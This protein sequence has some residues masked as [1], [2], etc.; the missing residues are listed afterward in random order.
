MDDRLAEIRA[1]LAD[2]RNVG[3]IGRGDV[4]R[5]LAEVDRLGAERDRY[6]ANRD[7]FRDALIELNGTL[8]E[9]EVGHQAWRACAD[10]LADALR[11]QYV[12]DMSGRA[13]VLAVY[14]TL[15]AEG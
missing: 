2:P 12:V 4:A 15:R 13:D 9:C 10:Q 1:R 14:D 3:I 5:L 11:E 6:H 8:D 7:E